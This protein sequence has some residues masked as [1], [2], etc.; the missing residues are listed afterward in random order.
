[1]KTRNKFFCGMFVRGSYGL[2]AATRNEADAKIFLRRT[3][4]EKFFWCVASQKK[5]KPHKNQK[6]FK[7]T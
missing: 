7:V 4:I 6:Y 1:M 2:K 3:E 5:K